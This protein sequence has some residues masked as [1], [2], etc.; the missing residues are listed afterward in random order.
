[1]SEST[2]RVASITGHRDLSEGNRR[3]IWAAMK[4]LVSNPKVTEIW[5][6]GAKGADNEA[7][8]AALHH[9]GTLSVPKLVVVVP[10]HLLHQPRECQLIIE[11]ADQVIE[12]K[13][14]IMADDRY[15]SYHRRN[16]FL[17][18]HASVLV[19]FWDGK[20]GSGTAST[21]NYAKKTKCIVKHIP[22][23]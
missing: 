14:P 16:E 11:R 9:R 13:N 3:V 15:A 2:H 12:L 8:K 21:V 23:G 1:M 18:D 22:M 6:G 5:F 7:L 4:G 10:D 20:P 17:V 19:A